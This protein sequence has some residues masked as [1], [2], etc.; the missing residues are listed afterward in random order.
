MLKILFTVVIF[1]LLFSKLTYADSPLTST[2]FYEAYLDYEIVKKA[3][4]SG[5]M[6]E[7]FANF[8]HSKKN[9]IDVKAAVINALGWDFDGKTNAEI[10]CSIIF[11]KTIKEI[12][13]AKLS[14][15]D[16][17]CIG[18]MLAMGDYFK[19]ERGKLILNKAV[20][21]L[22]SSY[23]VA[24]INALVEAQMAMDSDWCEV[25]KLINKVET[26]ENLSRDM[27]E[28]AVKIILDYINIYEEYCD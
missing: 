9:P 20:N 11:Y 2:P 4:E 1:S 26:N 15:G 25:W 17:F 27:N 18:Y 23:T 13:N 3:N 6:D 10:Y 5:V 22:K 24:M 19:P 8:L 7:E 12:N 16:Q 28:G 14:G 21:N